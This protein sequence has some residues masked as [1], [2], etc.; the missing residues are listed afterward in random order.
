MTTDRITKFLLGAIA[1]GLW[2]NV[3]AQWVR[4]TPLSAADADSTVIMRDV[5]AIATGSCINKH[6]C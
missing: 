6:I 5:H 2:M 4:P 1:L 3:V